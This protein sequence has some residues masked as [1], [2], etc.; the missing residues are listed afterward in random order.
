MAQLPDKLFERKE[1]EVDKK[2]LL[3]G[4]RAVECVGIF[5]NAAGRQLGLRRRFAVE[6]LHFVAVDDLEVLQGP[7]QIRLERVD[8]VGAETELSV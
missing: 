3:V 5:A 4:F 2:D 8:G 7:D 1:E 6:S